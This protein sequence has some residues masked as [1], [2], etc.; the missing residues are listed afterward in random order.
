MKRFIVNFTVIVLMCFA[1]VAKAGDKPVSSV[2]TLMISGK[3]QDSKN[4][5][6][7]AG[8]K[9]ECENCS[10][11][12]YSGLDGSFF[13]Y[14]QVTTEKE[15]KIEFSQVGYA[16]KTLDSKELSS[17]AGNLQVSLEEE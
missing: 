7:L 15:F 1:F 14:I 10:K 12:V 17:S 13:M 16:S 11:V 9:I 8:V 2:K 5:E 4:N 3:I 6:S